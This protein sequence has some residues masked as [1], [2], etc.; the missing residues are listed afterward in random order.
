MSEETKKTYQEE[1]QEKQF[2]ISAIGEA[3]INHCRKIEAARR[4]VEIALKVA[5]YC[6]DRDVTEDISKLA[7]K[8]LKINL[9]YLNSITETPIK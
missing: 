8:T 5:S 2:R 4:N 3:N 7:Q 9:E 1:L 6:Y